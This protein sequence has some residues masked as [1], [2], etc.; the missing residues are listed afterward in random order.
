MLPRQRLIVLV[1][2]V[3][4]VGATTAISAMDRVVNGA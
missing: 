3:V 2:L 1:V 4:N